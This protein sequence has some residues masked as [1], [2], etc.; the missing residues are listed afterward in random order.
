MPKLHVE[1][2][3]TFDV[4]NGKRLVNALR[5]EAGIEQLHACGGHGKCTTCRVAFLEGEPEAMTVRERQ[6][7]DERGVAGIR[8]S[9][10][11]L[12][13]NDMSVRADST[14]SNTVRSDCGPRPSD[15]M[16]P[17]PEWI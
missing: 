3:G 9:C 4:P 6:T 1:N 2:V 10:Q 11:I 5:D 16:E 7:L 8:L 17:T 13:E 14:L 12:C 15:T